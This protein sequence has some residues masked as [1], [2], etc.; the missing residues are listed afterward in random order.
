MK[1][2][3]YFNTLKPPE[4]PNHWL[5]A[6]ADFVVKPDATA[7]VFEMS[8]ADLRVAFKSIAL[9]SRGITLV[10][11]SP[12]SMQ[13]VATTL[14]FRYKDDIRV[15][16]IPLARQQSTL[17][18]YSASR[19]GYWDMGTNRRRLESWIDQLRRAPSPTP[20]GRD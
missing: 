20:P 4:T 8:A 1:P 14:V 5:I 13:L 2:D 16:F 7:P 17:A 18:I 9:Q 6:P 11:E 12:N 10:D 15:R 19:V 3:Q